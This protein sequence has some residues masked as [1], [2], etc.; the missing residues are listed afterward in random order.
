MIVP[1]AAGRKWGQPLNRESEGKTGVGNCQKTKQNN[2]SS[3]A[4]DFYDKKA[5]PYS[6]PF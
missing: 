4:I 5:H 6:L 2:K 3:L 1:L